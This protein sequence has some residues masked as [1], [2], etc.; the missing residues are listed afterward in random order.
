MQSQPH[1]AGP[2]PGMPAGHQAPPA[3]PTASAAAATR[4]FLLGL[5]A[6][7][8]LHTILRVLVSDAVERDEAEQLLW[9]QQLALGYGTQPP[10][11]TWLQWGVFQVAGVSVAGLAL[12]KNLLLA[13]TYAFSFLA[14]RT[15]LPP[16]NAA[17][18]AASMLL[19]PQI[20]WESQR[21]LTHSVLVTSLAACMLWQ[22]L[23]LLQR[24][25]PARYVLLGLATG[26]ALL[27]KY[28]AAACAALW[29]VALL[30]HRDTRSLVLRPA[31]LLVPLVVVA[32]LL[33]H[34]LWLLDHWADATGGTLAKM[35]AGTSNPL[36]WAEGVG[37]GLA[38][39]GQALLGF[40]ALLVVV[41]ALVCGRALWAGLRQP[42]A[43]PAGTVHRL[44]RRLV[45]LTLALLVLMVLAGAS[46]TFRDRWLQP[47]LF[48]LPLLLLG[49]LPQ[50][51]A[52]VLRRL[53]LA[54]AL[55]ATLVTVL[56]GLRVWHHGQGDDPD[57]L[58]MPVRA[59]AQALAV[60][61]L[62]AARLVAD[63]AVLG[64]GLRLHLPQAHV[65]LT[66]DRA[67]HAALPW[68]DAGR[69]VVWV[70]QQADPAHLRQAVDQA[71]LAAGRP[72]GA[73][74]VQTVLVPYLHAKPG[75][76]PAQLHWLALR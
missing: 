3:G 65:Q 42:P 1:H 54:M 17:L 59:F 32:V 74:Q 22:V 73:G 55:M 38:S 70:S 30:A 13:G 12:L 16:A 46:T 33:P 5:L 40:S 15:V 52:A 20:S 62:G 24:P 9:T 34:G 29:L 35:G 66:H 67:G 23:A 76:A 45:L 26:A 60:Q 8:A 2:G 63:D 72:P 71:A 7:F 43:G 6:Y 49:A 25:T 19:L 36:G 31:F 61:G 58:N 18:C 21:D 41:L 44:L 27:A 69:P 28:S 11:Y 75:S 51:G 57:E 56:L 10:L 53:G 37:L 39:L 48:M 68:P 47:F 50:P 4:I 64:G 14:A